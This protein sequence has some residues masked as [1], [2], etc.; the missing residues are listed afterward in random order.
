MTKQRSDPVSFCAVARNALC[1][2]A[3][4]PATCFKG[5]DGNYKRE[6]IVNYISNQQVSKKYKATILLLTYST[7]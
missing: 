3:T 4:V 7:T 1:F 2:R 6:Y 5:D